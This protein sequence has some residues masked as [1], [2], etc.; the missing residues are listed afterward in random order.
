MRLPFGDQLTLPACVEFEQT[1]GI[2]ELRL[3]FCAAAAQVAKISG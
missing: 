3:P 1:N 2:D